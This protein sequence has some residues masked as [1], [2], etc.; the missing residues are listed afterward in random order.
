MWFN[1]YVAPTL[2]NATHGVQGL[3]ADYKPYQT[4]INN[5]PGAPN[6]GNNNVQV[7]LNNG[8]S[9]TT[10]YNPGTGM[11]PVRVHHSAGTLQLQHR[12]V[13]LQGVFVPN[14]FKLRFNIDAFNAFNIQGR[15]KSGR[16]VTDGIQALTTSYWTPRQI[17]L[18]ARLTF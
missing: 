6:F 3:P 2:I 17:Q 10:A 5:T 11:D 16:N 13:A 14:R 12:H 18:S 8:T 15:V 4:P 9:V 7:P 1:G